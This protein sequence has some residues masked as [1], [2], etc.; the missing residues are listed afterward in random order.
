MAF[1]FSRSGVLAAAVATL[2]GACATVP[3]SPQEA[4]ALRAQARYDALIAKNYKQVYEFFA[5][6]YRERISYESWVGS[7]AP[8]ASFLSAK[9]VNVKCLSDDACDLQVESTYQAPRGVKASPKG[10]IERVTEQRWVRVDGEWW[11]YQD[12]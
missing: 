8:R 12:R 3:T 1:T 5:P 10:V 7:R 11:L 9:V 2:L 6:S 4:L